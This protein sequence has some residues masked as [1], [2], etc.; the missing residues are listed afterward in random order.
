MKTKVNLFLALSFALGIVLSS[1]MIIC[2][3]NYV[4]P[5]T[6]LASHG[7]PVK[8]FQTL[9]FFLVALIVIIPFFT[10]KKVMLPKKRENSTFIIFCSSLLGFLFAGYV[11]SF[12][13]IPLRERFNGADFP[14]AN[15]S[16]FGD[17][18]RIIYIAGVVLALP[19]A[20]YF[21]VLALQK[22]ITRSP[23]L[24]VLAV[25][26]ILWFS[27]RLIYYFMQT[28]AKVNIFGR[29]L[30]IVAFCLCVVFFMCE[31][32]LYIMRFDSA[33]NKEALKYT[34]LYL[35]SGYGAIVTLFAT[36]VSSTYLQAFWLLS[37]GETYISNAIFITLIL[38]ITSRIYSFSYVEKKADVSLGE[39]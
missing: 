39:A 30:T 34:R 37:P 19:C 31:A 11:V 1:L 32:R 9:A 36:Q 12:V 17:L 6:L 3:Y 38:Y 5:S 20:V 28:S 14:V 18:T 26:P 27:L 35:C 10:S 23:K 33:V 7:L 21:I 2:H 8:I 15:V 25:A 22:S 13:F 4:D 16:S 29:R 24:S